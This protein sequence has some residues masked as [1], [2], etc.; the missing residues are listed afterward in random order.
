M[1]AGLMLFT[2]CKKDIVQTTSAPTTTN[3]GGTTTTPPAN[4]SALDLIKD[5]VYLYAKE[6]YYWND[7]LPGY[8]TFNPRSY[9]GADDLTALQNEVNAYAQ[10]TV[11]PAT[12]KAY[13]YY[14]AGSK[15]AKY[16]FIDEGELATRLSA[17][18]AAI[19]T[20]SGDYGFAPFYNA[21]NDLRVKYVYPG[22]PADAAGLKRG[23]QI[24][25]VNGST[26]IN[27]SNSSQYNFVLNAY[28]A[29]TT[30]TL[31]LKR[32][33][34]STFNASITASN[35]KVNPILKTSVIDAGN[36]KKVGY[37]VFNSY[38]SLSAAQA[39]LDA[40]FST[41]ATGGITDLIV[42][43]R[44]NG[45]GY[46]ETAEYIDNLIAPSSANGSMMYTAYYNANLTNGNAPLLKNQVRR[47]DATNQLYNYAQ[48]NYTVTGNQVKFAK[49]GAIMGL[50][51]VVF[52]VSGSTASASELTINNLR[53]YMNVQLVGA[54]TY[55]KPVGF[56]DI[57]INK[58]TLYTPEF[59]TKNSAG[60][61]DY[62][63]GMTPGSPDYP[64]KIVKDDLTK[65]FGDTSEG[66]LAS[67]LSYIKNGV[68][69]TTNSVQTESLSTLQGDGLN[70]IN[71]EMEKNSFKGML[72]QH[73]LKHN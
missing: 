41:F 18:K 20:N 48:V 17:T 23:Y 45:G 39:G 58:Y 14:S 50:S 8:D 67:A 29:N 42:D 1:A 38:V 62:Y 49:K 34:G 59:E 66:M 27:G 2:A 12:G 72:Y 32:P 22:S 6:D 69:P 30:I 16:S 63:A 53:P 65:D 60:Q 4:G 44:Y 15:E 55:G 31:T 10:L 33:D 43:L 51:R 36:G 7:Q 40:A 46:V 21:A 52:L 71:S 64:G 56:F 26:A 28:T 37:L 35:Y 13:E 25:S 47:D 70:H 61:G 19:T 54:T 5:S 11:N 57:K 68:Y 9:T 3:G 73:H 24:T